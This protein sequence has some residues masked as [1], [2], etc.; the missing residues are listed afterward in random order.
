MNLDD[1]YRALAEQAKG[2]AA[3]YG[4]WA[5]SFEADPEA[6]LFFGRMAAEEVGHANLADYQ[7]RV[8]RKANPALPPDVDLVLEE[9]ML[10]TDISRRSAEAPAR[11]LEEALCLASWM[12][13][14]VA[15]KEL[16]KTVHE[17][18]PELGRLLASLGGGDR[19]HV[20]RLEAFAAKRGIPL[21]A[22]G[23]P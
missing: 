10:L 4:R 8:L 23:E 12:E 18:D 13:A 3:L 19:R 5:D 16:R 7:R 20:E 15:E 9:I 17:T 2:M 6:A 11:S 1:A 22:P 21:H 14:S